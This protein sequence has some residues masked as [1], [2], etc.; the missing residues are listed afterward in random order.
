MDTKVTVERGSNVREN[1]VRIYD[2][3][4]LSINHQSYTENAA[5]KI[6]KFVTG[7]NLVSNN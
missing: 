2:T 4:I 1:I 6:G 3:C 7:Y 5:T